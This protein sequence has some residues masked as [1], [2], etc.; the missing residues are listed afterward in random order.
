MVLITGL[1]FWGC[2]MQF[3]LSAM[4]PKDEKST[5]AS[6]IEF[7]IVHGAIFKRIIKRSSSQNIYTLEY[8]TPLGIMKHGLPGELISSIIFFVPHER[9]QAKLRALSQELS[10][11]DREESIRKLQ[12]DPMIGY[13]NCPC[14]QYGLDKNED[15]CAIMFTM[16]KTVLNILSKQGFGIVKMP[17]I[18]RA[19]PQCLASVV[20]DQR[21]VP[22]KKKEEDKRLLIVRLP[23]DW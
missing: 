11:E 12:P 14:T 22:V 17:E 5:E 19:S 3:S 7:I 23:F 15:H 21:I 20:G 10:K 18:L 8:A 6:N 2:L 9:I 4:D 13:V 1:F 16:F